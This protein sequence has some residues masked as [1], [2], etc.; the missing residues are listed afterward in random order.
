ML[1][2]LRT[3]LILMALVALAV[4]LSATEAATSLPLLVEA[5]LVVVCAFV[6][7]FRD[8]RNFVRK[9][10]GGG[11]L[12]EVFLDCPLSVC[13][14][15]DPK[16]LYK[17]ARSGAVSTF[18]GV[19]SPYETPREPELTIKTDKTAVDDGVTSCLALSWR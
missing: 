15:R 6:S 16:G 5:G 12:I 14:A 3:G 18:T 4:P 2:P 8:D 17:G 9:L 7:P 11:S 1:S 19:S 13:E 10:V